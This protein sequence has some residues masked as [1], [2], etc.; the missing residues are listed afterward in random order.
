[1]REQFAAPIQRDDTQRVERLQEGMAGREVGPSSAPGQSTLAERIAEGQAR[2][3][4]EQAKEAAE[5]SVAQQET[6]EEAQMQQFND[7][8]L[9]TIERAM[10]IKQGLAQKTE[11]LLNSL[12]RQER[13]IDFQKDAAKMEQVG[14]NLRMNNKK[15]IDALQQNAQRARL[16]DAASF[17]EELQRAIFEDERELFDTNLEFKRLM[18]AEQREFLQQLSDISLDA[19][20]EMGRYEA[21]TANELGKWK[22]VGGIVSGATQAY[23]K[24]GK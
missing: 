16:D 18:G 2:A 15:Y 19:A 6:A 5:V 8:Q 11:A 13:A 24:S 23:A 9:A 21:K 12:E 17:R 14:F 4:M 1:M 10:G 20:L 22:G 7:E 3:Q